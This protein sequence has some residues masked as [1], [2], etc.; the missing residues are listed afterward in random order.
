M[1]TTATLLFS[2]LLL[3]GPVLAADYKVDPAHTSVVFEVGHLEV[4][5]LVG[6][7]NEF[8]GDYHFDG[9]N[10]SAARA[11]L[12]IQ[13]ESIDTNHEDRDKHLRSPDFFDVRQ[14][15]TLSFESTGYEGDK[16]S[17]TLAGNLT[18]HGVTQPVAFDVRFIG[19]GADPWGGYR[20]GFSAETRIKRSDFGMSYGLPGVGDEIAI[21]L[22]IEGI[23]Q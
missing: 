4:S 8:E 3:A 6:R 11:R 20:N 19:E 7:F 17:G 5:T 15:P 23:R 16:D 10:P 13:A 22:F 18:V 14:Y 1:K 21:R 9:D 2:S 12:T